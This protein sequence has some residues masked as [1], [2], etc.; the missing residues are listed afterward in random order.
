MIFLVISKGRE[1]YVYLETI[2]LVLYMIKFK[3]IFN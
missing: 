1:I 2:C 3:I